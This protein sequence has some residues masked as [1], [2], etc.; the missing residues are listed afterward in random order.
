MT[1][2]TENKRAY[3][4]PSLTNYGSITELT[5]GGGSGDGGGGLG[6]GIIVDL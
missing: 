5:R 4:A 6:I 1:Q 2:R 3:R